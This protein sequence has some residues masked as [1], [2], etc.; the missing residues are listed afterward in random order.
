MTI[1]THCTAGKLAWRRCYSISIIFISLAFSPPQ[2]FPKPSPRVISRF[3]RRIKSNEFSSSTVGVAAAAARQ[4]SNGIRRRR[5]Q[6]QLLGLKCLRNVWLFLLRLATTKSKSPMSSF[7]TA[8]HMLETRP[9]CCVFQ[10]SL[11]NMCVKDFWRLC[12]DSGLVLHGRDHHRRERKDF[13][14]KNVFKDRPHCTVNK[15]KSKF[16]S[17]ATTNFYLSIRPRNSSA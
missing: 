11:S 6:H 8:R 15:T 10:T 12:R 4:K 13:G 14:R 7:E 1:S 3:T 5:L 17:L 2:W 9:A 16:N